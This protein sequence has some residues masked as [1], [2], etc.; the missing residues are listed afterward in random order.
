MKN[1]DTIMQI[2]AFLSGFQVG[3][4]C[5]IFLVACLYGS[6]AFGKQTTQPSSIS[7]NRVTTTFRDA[8]GFVWLGTSRELAQLIPRDGN[9]KHIGHFNELRD[10]VVNS[11]ARPRT[12]ASQLLFGVND[13]ILTLDSEL[14]R[15]NTRRP[16]IVLSAHSRYEQLATVYSSDKNKAETIELGHED[17]FIDFRFAALNDASSDKYH[18]RYRLE[19]YDDDWIKP[20]Q[21]QSA[22]YRS[23]PAGD[24][25][26]T[27][28]ASSNDG[29]WNEQGASF[30][31]HVEPPPWQT[32]WAYSFYAIFFGGALVSYKHNK[33]KKLERIAKY[34]AKLESEVT[35]RTR[36]LL[37]RN[38]E[39]NALNAK[40][41][42]ASFTDPLT[43]LKNRR[44]LYESVS[45]MVASA[46]RR[47]ESAGRKSA[48]FHTAAIAPSM[49]FMMID[50][51]G[52][53]LIND[54]Y[55]HD[56]GDRALIQVREVLESTC[57]KADTII[58]W[59]GDEFMVVG[60][61]TSTRAVERLA[62][63]L[64]CK[65]AECQY[66]LGNGHV[67][68]LSGSIGFAMYPFSPLKRTGL[69]NWEQVVVVADRA[70][71]AAKKSG[72]NAWVGVYG[73]RK[74]IWGE[75]TANKIELVTLAEQGMINVHSS[76][77]V[78]MGFAQQTKQ[79]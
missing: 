43:G 21:V 30:R 16:D 72:R 31:L 37:E 74:S 28:K 61:N 8:D 14:L 2:R 15:V 51:D 62:E 27:V 5:L 10:D 41:R 12:S 17:D 44:Y 3:Q 48:E 68:R 38:D 22:T 29:V 60:D 66:R 73:T 26:F 67:G 40:L 34:N 79:G 57:R 75:F 58:R 76:S 47:T 70:S 13:S 55:G 24:Y 64:R 49:F 36:E 78:A 65:I 77:D 59:G 4:L 39:L 63:R 1:T 71:Y 56:A 23:L 9:P 69:L 19:G 46:E 42:E 52:F 50:L 25:T 11:G 7:D 6:T 33:N 32:L 35:A 20:G 53:K 18:Y 45:S 54:T